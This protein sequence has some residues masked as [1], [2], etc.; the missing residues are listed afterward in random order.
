MGQKNHT[1]FI[2]FK[3]AKPRSL[4]NLLVLHGTLTDMVIGEHR[5]IPTSISIC[6]YYL[7]HHVIQTLNNYSLLPLPHNISLIKYTKL[8]IIRQTKLLL[9]WFFQLSNSH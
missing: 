6:Q 5:K 4:H 8:K 1:L 2:L 3:S 9:V 7:S